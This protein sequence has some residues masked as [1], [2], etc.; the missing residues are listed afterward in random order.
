MLIGP[1]SDFAGLLLLLPLLLWL[2]LPSGLA[3]LL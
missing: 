1:D 3:L 2:L